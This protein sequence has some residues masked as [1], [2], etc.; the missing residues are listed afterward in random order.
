LSTL[1][2]IFAAEHRRL[3]AH[4]RGLFRGN[5]SLDAEDII[6]DVFLATFNAQS[7]S[8]IDDTLAYIYRAISNRVIDLRRK[9]GGDELS[10]DQCDENGVT[11]GEMLHDDRTSV[12]ESFN[13]SELRDSL[14]AALAQLSELER[15]II[16]ENEFESKSFAQLSRE[17]GMPV[18]TLLSKKSR[19]MKKLARILDEREGDE[20]YEYLDIYE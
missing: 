17:T 4:V 8:P 9:K 18:G 15:R 7:V 5:G 10:S 14:F 13:G 19:A 16:I 1:I 2:E 11:L 6:Q 12:E 3:L 20:I